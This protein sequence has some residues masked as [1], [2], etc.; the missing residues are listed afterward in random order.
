MI[1]SSPVTQSAGSLAA[2]VLFSGVC[3][4]M[5]VTL[6]RATDTR[7]AGRD[8]WWSGAGDATG[9]PADLRVR[10]PVAGWDRPG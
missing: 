2:S 5:A 10:R 3:S 9:A 1:G 4:V 6:G 7:T 8:G